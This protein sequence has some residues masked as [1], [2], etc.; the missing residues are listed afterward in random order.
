MKAYTSS[1]GQLAGNG[2]LIWVTLAELQQPGGVVSDQSV[3]F[4]WVYRL[5]AVG[6][7]LMLLAI[8]YVWVQSSLAG[9]RWRARNTVEVAQQGA[10]GRA[11]KERLRF[12]QLKVIRGTDVKLLEIEAEM[13]DSGRGLSSGSYGPDYRTRNLIF[14]EP[15]NGN[16]RWLFDA[17]EQLIRK[18]EMLS[19]DSDDHPGPVLAIYLEVEKGLHAE[20]EVERE[21]VPALVQTNGS[22]Y[23]ELGKPVSRVL[24]QSVN[25]DGKTLGLLLEDQNKL[26]YRE[27]SLESFSQTSE[28][29]ITRLD[30]Q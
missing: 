4:R 22:G 24:D 3:F 26:L 7:L 5:L 11:K 8:A 15:G 23:V 14:L 1:G 19:V 20:S 17:N 25:A 16:V 30:R 21:V 12:D 18:T 29:L 13:D 9:K 28:K 10:D 2:N 6:G 27:Y